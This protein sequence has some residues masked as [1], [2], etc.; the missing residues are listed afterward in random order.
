MFQEQYIRP[1][2]PYANETLFKSD[3]QETDVVPDTQL[4]EKFNQISFHSFEQS[5]E[6]DREQSLETMYITDFFLALA[7]CNTVV[8]SSPNQPRQKV[9]KNSV[10]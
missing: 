2:G 7:I 3:K 1:L 10:T 9:R 6:T 8:V 5:E 4:L